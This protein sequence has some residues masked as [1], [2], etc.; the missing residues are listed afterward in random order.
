MKIVKIQINEFGPLSNR[1]FDFDQALTVIRGENES[2]KSTLLLFIKF[3]L[4]GLSKRAKGGSVAEIDRALTRDGAKASGYMIVSCGKKAY[5]IDRYISKS[6]RNATERVQVTDLD[7]GE[8][9]DYGN[10]PGEFLLGIPAEIFENS[11]GISQLF[12]ILFSFAFLLGYRR[13]GRT[14]ST[15]LSA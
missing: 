14:E 1:T 13:Q 4:Y 5:R 11:C 15:Y 10:S 6:S 8:A 12:L 7:T 2:G 9:C 3:A